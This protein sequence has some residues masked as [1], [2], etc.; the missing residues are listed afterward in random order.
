MLRG[1]YGLRKIRFATQKPELDTVGLDR[2]EGFLRPAALPRK[3]KTP[4]A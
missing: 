1:C 4:Q 3:A 2:Q